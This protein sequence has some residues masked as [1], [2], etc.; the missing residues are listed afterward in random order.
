MRDDRSQQRTGY[1]RETRHQEEPS[2]DQ[3]W[4]QYLDGGYF[5]ANDYLKPDL[6]ARQKLEP[7]ARQLGTARPPLTNH[8][9]RRFFQHC[10]AI[11]ARLKGRTSTW[12]S[13]RVELS[14]L[15]F[16]AADAFPKPPKPA[17]IPKIFHEF[18]RRNVQT[19]KTE[20][21]FLKGFLPHFEALVGFSAQHLRDRERT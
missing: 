9:L 18:I 8:Q 13:E 19:V 16:A 5:L 3:L 1:R 17:K 6:V 15:D 7:L 20:T 10:R 14:K 21:D 4:P 12:E 11:E 2:L